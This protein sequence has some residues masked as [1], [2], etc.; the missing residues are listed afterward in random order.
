MAG[1]R[2]PDDPPE[3][4]MHG[5][6]PETDRLPSIL[7]FQSGNRLPTFDE[8]LVGHRLVEG[9]ELNAP[10]RQQLSIGAH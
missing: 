10:G 4:P 1:L 3:Y 7:T 8:F 5:V 9:D 2:P 6:Q